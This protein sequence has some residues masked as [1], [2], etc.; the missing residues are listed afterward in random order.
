MKLD[1][2]EVDTLHDVEEG[3]PQI[4][5]VVRKIA[6]Y[7]NKMRTWGQK[8]KNFCGN[9]LLITLGLIERNWSRDSTGKAPQR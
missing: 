5:Y 6:V 8:P 4:M 2:R 3:E 9:P 1:K 7:E